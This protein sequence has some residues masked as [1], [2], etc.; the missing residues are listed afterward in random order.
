[1]FLRTQGLLPINELYA[2][3]PSFVSDVTHGVPRWDKNLPYS[4]RK[5]AGFVAVELNRPYNPI[6]VDVAAS[7]AR[8]DEADELE[9]KLVKWL[10]SKYPR[11]RV[12]EKRVVF[13]QFPW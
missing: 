10:N 12:V 13:T 6:E 3:N 9:H 8:V 7:P 1:M 2:S 4:W 11:V 5:E